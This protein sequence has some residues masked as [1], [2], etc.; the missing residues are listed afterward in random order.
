M[1]KVKVVI[2]RNDRKI[3]GLCEAAIKKAVN[4]SLLLIQADA[5]ANAPKNLGQLQSSIDVDIEQDG[6]H[7]TGSVYTDLEHAMY[8]EFGTG[9]KGAANHEGVSPE[10]PVAYRTSRWMIPFDA[11]SEADAEKY[12][13]IKIRKEGIVIGY[14][15]YGQPAQPFLYPA[16]MN[17]QKNID[18]IFAKAMEEAI[19]GGQV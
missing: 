14:I 15:T 3:K 17:N 19:K 13:F 8:V 18:D 12:H 4:D 11:I 6:N 5:I 9:P 1:G 2:K 16:F 10:V 7:Y